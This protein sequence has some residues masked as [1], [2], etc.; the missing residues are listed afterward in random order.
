MPRIYHSASS[1]L[2]ARNGD[3]GCDYAW[4]LRYVAGIRDPEVDWADIESGRV[5]VLPRDVP[6]PPGSRVFCTP[7]QRSTS[8]GKATH[9]IGELWYLGERPDWE[10]FP[11]QV[12]ASGR[13]HLPAP[14]ECALIEVEHAIGDIPTGID[15]PSACQFMC[16][17]DGVHYAGN[18]DLLVDISAAAADRLGLRSGI[19]QADY[20][21]S[22]SLS[23][24]QKSTTDLL[25]DLQC[26]LYTI[27]A[28]K[29]FDLNEIQ[30]RWVYLETKAVRRSRPTDVVMTLDRALEIIARYTPTVHRV[31]Q[32][33]TLEEA[34]KNPRN[35]DRYGGCPH[36]V[37]LGG[38]CNAR[39]SIG[40]SLVQIG[41]KIMSG[42]T[43]EQRAKFDRFK[44]GGIA[45]VAAVA[46]AALPEDAP[47]EPKAAPA[48]PKRTRKPKAAPEP[49]SEFVKGTD[50]PEIR[51]AVDDNGEVVYEEVVYDDEQGEDTQAPAAEDAAPT[52]QASPGAVQY[53]LQLSADLAKAQAAV[54]E[55]VVRLRDALS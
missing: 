4:A 24:Y 3:E 5:Q 2:T 13:A 14:S 12:F 49:S 47:P 38:P 23:R 29:R 44:K 53:V 31:D 32:I 11:G 41:K 8:L 43:P 33:T 30:S 19:V 17:V 9:R 39:R 7:R 16:E 6:V 34:E 40:T 20:K 37:S 26:A 18:R 48:A 28:C 45:A 46:E 50:A 15:E 21:T 22:S 35:C 54:D 27:D 36:H 25:D 52:F 10:S 51:V 1:V 55:I 42:L